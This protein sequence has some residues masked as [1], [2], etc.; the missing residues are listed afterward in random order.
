MGK[1]T[2]KEKRIRA[3]T[4]KKLQEEGVIPPDKKKLNRKKF[5]DEAADEWN[6]WGK[7]C[8]MWEYYLTEAIGVMLSDVERNT[9]R[10][11]LEAVGAAKCLKLA[12]R[13]QAFHEMVRERGDTTYTIK[14]KYDYIRDILEA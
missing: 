10:V 8:C 1:L 7:D 12:V 6:S 5:V 11:S 3:K 2:Q 13:L 14:E 4:K 9:L